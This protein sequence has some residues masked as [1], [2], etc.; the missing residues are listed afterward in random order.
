MSGS[1]KKGKVE[2]D[3]SKQ[4]AEFV[5]PQMER[6][7]VSYKRMLPA[8]IMASVLLL[9]S[10]ILHPIPFQYEPIELNLPPPPPRENVVPLH[11][12]CSIVISS[13]AHCSEGVAVD[14]HG[15]IFAGYHNGTIVKIDTN[16]KISTVA[17]INGYPLGMEFD[18]H[19]N[20][21]VCDSLNNNL[22]SFEN[23]D[24]L[25]EPTILVKKMFDKNEKPISFLDDLTISQKTGVI[26]FTDASQNVWNSLI[27][28]TTIDPAQIQTLCVRE[29]LEAQTTGRVLAYDPSTKQVSVIAE[30]LTFANG[31]VIDP[32]NEDYLL[33]AETFRFKI[34]KI[35]LITPTRGGTKVDFAQNLIGIPDGMA[36]SKDGK[37][38]WVGIHKPRTKFGHFVLDKPY[39]KQLMGRLSDKVLKVIGNLDKWGMVLQIDIATGKVVH[40]LLDEHGDLIRALGSIRLVDDTLYLGSLTGNNVVKCDIKPLLK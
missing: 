17:Q 8:I 34:S 32:I 36:I 13:D 20:L 31:I 4:K 11:G 28:N 29:Y 33:V 18:A 9:I 10:L 2:I 12:H 23:L 30:G 5:H 40:S 26:Y 3:E 24:S 22:L 15:N 39:L 37:Y 25:S 38:L 1:N 14:E 16:G 6:P 27:P 35:P 7:T 21:I 19:N